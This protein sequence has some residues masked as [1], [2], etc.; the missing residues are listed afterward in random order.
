M[1][2][3]DQCTARDDHQ[4]LECIRHWIA[5]WA[6]C[7]VLRKMTNAAK[8]VVARH[9]KPPQAEVQFAQIATLVSLSDSPQFSAM[10][11]SLI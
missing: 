3:D 8:T 1:T 6:Q 5:L 10:Q 9:H 4:Q 7:S 2:P 11:C